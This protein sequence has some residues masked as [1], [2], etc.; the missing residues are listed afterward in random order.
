V[1]S[2]FLSDRPKMFMIKT[3]GFRIKGNILLFECEEMMFSLQYINVVVVVKYFLILQGD[4]G[5]EGA[6]GPVFEDF[7]QEWE[8][9]K[10]RKRKTNFNDCC[11]CILKKRFRR[12]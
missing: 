11:C 2:P 4:L 9:E 3:D 5:M 8:E 12:N 6:I 1:A 10:E 7:E